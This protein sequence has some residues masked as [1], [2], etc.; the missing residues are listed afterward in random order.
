MAVVL[1]A[2]AVALEMAATPVAPRLWPGA[3]YTV[4]DRDRAAVRALN[5]IYAVARD[6]ATF[7]DWGHD[8]LMCF[9]NVAS[10]SGNRK[11]AGMAARMGRERAVAWRRLYPKVPG[12]AAASLIADLVT[13]SL[14]ANAF[15]V[16]D[17]R[18]DA[19]L[20]AAA[21]QFSVTDYLGFD[22]AHQ[23]P[24][25]YEVYLD[26]L[27]ASYVGDQFGVKL[28]AH[29][30]AV[31][32]WLP[33]MRPYPARPGSPAWYDALYS[34]THTVYTY[35]GYNLSRI[36][37]EC[38]P[39]ER[40]YL[41]AAL[42]EAVRERD[43]ESVGECL[44]SLQALGL[45]YADAPIRTG[46]EYLLATQNPDG[47]WGNPRDP[48]LYNRYHAAWTGIGG[49]QSFRWTRVLGCPAR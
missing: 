29:Y 7:G 39:R 19:A 17:A 8:L 4:A 32:R 43:P 10:T 36:R 44:D 31:L 3:R 28:G 34:I 12:N 1:A 9:A 27:V 37:P 13:G 47:S 5:Y 26:A 33:A 38:F 25:S 40:D 2:A 45:T 35:N 46:V 6:R 49:I 23:A 16:R 48:D 24:P 41:E 20:R 14:Y 42:P 30:P 11:L 22:P 18:F 21:G 15:G